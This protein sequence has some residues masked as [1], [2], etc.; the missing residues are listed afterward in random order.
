MIS[1]QTMYGRN[2]VIP[3]TSSL[4]HGLKSTKSLMRAQVWW[5]NELTMLQAKQ[6][7]SLSLE[8]VIK[9][10]R[11]VHVWIFIRR[12]EEYREERKVS[13]V[14]ACCLKNICWG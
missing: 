13:W 11:Y 2:G 3:L 9:V 1:P 5:V 14:A 7:C 6:V 4:T 12:S 8:E 10:V